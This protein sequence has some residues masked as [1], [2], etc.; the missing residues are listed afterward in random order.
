MRTR[1]IFVGGLCLVLELLAGPV[2]ATDGVLEINLTCATQTGCFS[3]DAAGLPVTITKPGSYRL[4]SNLAT[5]N[6]AITAISIATSDAS[7]DLNGF[8][9]GCSFGLLVPPACSGVFGTGSGVAVDDV[10]TRSNVAVRDGVIRDMGGDGVRVGSQGVV[11]GVRAIDNGANGIAAGVEISP[12]GA[13]GGQEAR[14]EANTASGNGGHGIIAGYRSL[15]SGNT[16]VD[17]GDRGLRGPGQ[18]GLFLG[19]Y[20]GNVI[21]GNAGGTVVGSLVDLGGNVCD[22]ST[23]CP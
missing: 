4:T 13:Q 21:S 15:I 20:R 19:G 1:S 10:F 14:L 17:N 7:L 18:L 11:T 5:G 3:G 16:I 23:S 8:T 2:A 12:F 6:N 22:A 9:I